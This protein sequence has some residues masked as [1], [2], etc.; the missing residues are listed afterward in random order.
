MSTAI[1]KAGNSP[2]KALREKPCSHLPTARHVGQSKG[3]AQGTAG[4]V[5]SPSCGP[6]PLHVK[7]RH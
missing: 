1:Q 4:S 3:Q 7:R 5:T 2:E 6:E